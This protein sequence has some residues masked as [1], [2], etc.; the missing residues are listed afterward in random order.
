MSAGTVEQHMKR[1]EIKPLKF[2]ILDII[3]L[4]E[5]DKGYY[6]GD[7]FYEAPAASLPDETHPGPTEPPPTQPPPPPPPTSLT[8][9]GSDIPLEI[10]QER[11]KYDV[12]KNPELMDKFHTFLLQHA[13]IDITVYPAGPVD[14]M[15]E[16]LRQ[17]L[18]YSEVLET[19][20]PWMKKRK[21]YQVPAGTPGFPLQ[22]FTKDEITSAL[23]L[24]SSTIGNIM[25]YF[26]HDRLL[27]SPDA[28]EWVNSQGEKHS[29]TFNRM[30]PSVWK[31]RLAEG[32]AEANR[33]R[34]RN[35]SSSSGSGGS[36]DESEKRSKKGK[37]AKKKHRSEK[38]DKKNK[39][40]Y[41]SSRLDE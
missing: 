33:K 18:A 16:A 10:A 12:L 40:G 38:K 21:G 41:D 2:D 1:L 15:A 39:G 3:K 24:K 23:N 9:S 22:A 14:D 34:R 28:L 26:K 4:Q 36:S 20:K 7:I 6:T 13:G 5:T 35:A 17:H 29:T 32:E 27:N 8:G 31:K 25:G 11:E 19:F 30:K 37:S